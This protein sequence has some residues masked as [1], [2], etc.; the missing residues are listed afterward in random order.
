MLCILLPNNRQHLSYSRILTILTPVEFMV[1]EE[2]SHIVSS[3][4]DTDVDQIPQPGGHDTVRVGAD[5]SDKGRSE[6]LVSVEELGT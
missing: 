4:P 5:D 3:K 2:S 1:D 6:K